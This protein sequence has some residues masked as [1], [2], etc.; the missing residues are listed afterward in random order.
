MQSQKRS[1]KELQEEFT[2][3]TEKFVDAMQ[4]RELFA[5]SLR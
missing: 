3:L 5:V 4:K 1:D 2:S